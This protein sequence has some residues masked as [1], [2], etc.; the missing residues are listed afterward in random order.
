MA[1]LDE[2]ACVLAA[3][4]D[5]CPCELAAILDEC[6]CVLAAILNEGVL[7]MP[8]IVGEAGCPR[9]YKRIR[10]MRSNED[11]FTMFLNTN[12]SAT[13]IENGKSLFHV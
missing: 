2:C 13:G 7:V 5:G 10:I 9:R 12:I 4:L 3:I 1:V 6:T 8:A 11:V